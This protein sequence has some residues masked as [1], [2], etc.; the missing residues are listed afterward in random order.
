MTNKTPNNEWQEWLPQQEKTA[1]VYPLRIRQMWMKHGKVENKC[2]KCIFFLRIRYA[3]VYRKCEKT[4]MTGGPGTD[5]LASWQAC[6]LF[7]LAEKPEIIYAP[8]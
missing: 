6:G 3:K 5:W 4:K 2:G 8:K 7:K 1:E